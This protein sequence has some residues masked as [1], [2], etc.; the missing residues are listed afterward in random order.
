M[1]VY[2][3]QLEGFSGPCV[4][5]TPE[6]VLDEVRELLHPNSCTKGNTIKIEVVEMTEAELEALPEFAGY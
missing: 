5:R 1:K 6:A 4:H 3:V 2:A